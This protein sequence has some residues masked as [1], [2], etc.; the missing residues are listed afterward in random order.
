M[1]DE[2]FMIGIIQID[3]HLRDE[4]VL[5]WIKERA[6]AEPMQI[7]AG[8]VSAVF[9]CHPNTSRAILQRLVHAGRIEVAI[10]CYRGGMVY[11][12]KR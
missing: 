3:M 9:K 5:E 12:V 1:V 4:R 7:A 10:E 2:G 8:T 6:G 11:K